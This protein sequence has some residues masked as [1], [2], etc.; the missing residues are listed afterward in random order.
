MLSGSKA[1]V[2]WLLEEAAPA[3]AGVRE[4]G[5]CRISLTQLDKRGSSVQLL[6]AMLGWWDVLDV[7]LSMM[8]DPAAR[9][10][11]ALD[12]WVGGQGGSCG[13]G[14]RGRGRG[15]RGGGRGRGGGHPVQD[16]G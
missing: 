13:S 9:G 12:E 5:A 16:G 11:D 6:C 14:R 10:V 2:L 7:M 8:L 3:A 4:S 15:G 1:L